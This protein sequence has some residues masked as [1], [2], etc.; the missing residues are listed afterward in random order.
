MCILIYIHNPLGQIKG[1][2]ASRIWGITRRIFSVIISFG[3]IILIYQQ[4]CTDKIN[5]NGNVF[6]YDYVIALNK[7][8]SK[9]NK[10]MQKDGE[11]AKLKHLWGD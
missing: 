3:F 9:V 4:I 10:G 7:W 5:F 11:N 8:T 1:M 2:L 6:L